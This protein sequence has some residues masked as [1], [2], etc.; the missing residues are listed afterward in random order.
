MIRP[1]PSRDDPGTITCPICQAYFTPLGRQIYCS[2]P[3][4][5]TAFRR[6]H[7]SPTAA[8]TIP[9]ARPRRDYNH[10]RMPRLRRTAL[11]RTTLAR[12]AAASP[13]ASE[14]AARAHTATSP[15]HSPTY[16]TRR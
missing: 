16:S 8:V 13:A 2:T 15:S 11:R 10:L 12:T 9:A 1:V 4:R 7:H 3:C 6:R 5:K 14:S